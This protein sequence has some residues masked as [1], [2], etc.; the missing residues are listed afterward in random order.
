MAEVLAKADESLS[1][2]EKQELD[3]AAG[4]IFIPFPFTTKKVNAA[5]YSG[6][7]P[8]WQMFIKIA[9]DADLKARIRSKLPLPALR[10]EK[11]AT[12]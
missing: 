1:E 2:K 10:G 7:D 5:P 4:S 9:K 3:E 8:E 12:G 11:S 6:E